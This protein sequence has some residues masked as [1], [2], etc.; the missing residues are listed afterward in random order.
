[1][2]PCSPFAFWPRWQA[3]SFCLPQA[4]DL[5][6]PEDRGALPSVVPGLPTRLSTSE[7]LKRD[8]E[9]VGYPIVGLV[10][11]LSEQFGEAGRHLHWGRPPRT[12][13]TRR[14][15]CNCAKRRR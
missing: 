8:T 4:R 9:N 13:W 6:L 14:R 5:V 15:C 2:P 7:Q 12:S 11:Q 10:R 1:M 3:K